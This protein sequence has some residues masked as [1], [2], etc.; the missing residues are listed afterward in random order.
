V[1]DIKANSFISLINIYNKE[2]LFNKNKL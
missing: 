2:A 1:V